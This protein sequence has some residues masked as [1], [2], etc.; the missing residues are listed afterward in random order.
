M[1]YT[2]EFKG[3][4]RVEPKLSQE[5]IEFFT[6]F[7]ETRRMEC[8][9]GP[10]YVNRGGSFG[11]DSTDTGVISYNS[12]PSG[13]PGLW[14]QWIPTEDGQ[15]IE[16][17]GTEKFY[18]SVEWMQYLITHFF[19]DHPKAAEE[20][21]FLKSHLLSGRIEAHGEE[22]GDRWV[23]IVE[24]N[25]VTQVEHPIIGESITCPHC[26]ESFILEK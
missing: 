9:Q 12:P 13:Q 14:C 11:Q 6:K 22:Y 4:I 19:G 2:T 10:Y 7:T 18:N 16:W 3:Q 5:E 23:L 20:L 26:E 17:N 8:D 25:T 24:N 1:G 15:F 21:P